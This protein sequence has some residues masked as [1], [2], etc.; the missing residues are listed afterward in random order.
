[1]DQVG[2]WLVGR[3]GRVL[4]GPGR[5]YDLLAVCALVAVAAL[6]PVYFPGS[7]L[8]WFTG[9]LAV[10]FCPGYALISALFP[11]RKEILAQSF[12]VRRE[13]RA[14]T[15]SM[16]ER[17]ALAVGLSASVV[18]LVAVALTRGLWELNEASVGLT[19]IVF[20]FALS[21]LAIYRRARL[22][23]GDQFSL[24]AK[25]LDLDRLNSSERVVGAIIAAS[26]VLL[27]A[28]TVTGLQAPPA[29]REY[30]EF[31]L[32]GADD[33]L[34]HLPQSLS[35]G[36]QGLVKVGAVNHLGRSE[37]YT[38][39]VS[40]DPNSSNVPFDPASPLTLS[41]GS[42]GSTTFVLED[43]ERF[44]TTL[45]FSVVGSGERTVYLRLLDSSGEEVRRLW[46]P[47]VVT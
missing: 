6:L 27:V 1:M 7:P 41:P 43:E 42:G 17:S 5:P 11:G 15:I 14:F 18:S 24:V 45:T 31:Y 28:V 33:N 10:F 19:I 29:E 20:T 37:T 23:P 9:F 35:S 47:L 38:L 3:S 8:A 26:L 2:E 32:N 25:P 16:L 4:V 44:E 21:G 13:E 22:P 46:M 12:I 34:E 39:V 40:L 30:T 36:Q